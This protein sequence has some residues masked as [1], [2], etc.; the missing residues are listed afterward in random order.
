MWH[1]LPFMLSHHTIIRIKNGEN[2][3]TVPYRQEYSNI[4]SILS[5]SSKHKQH[6][7]QCICLHC[8]A[9]NGTPCPSYWGSYH[10][11]LLTKL[12]FKQLFFWSLDKTCCLGGTLLEKMSTK[13][14]IPKVWPM[15]VNVKF[16]QEEVGTF[17]RGGF[18]PKD[19]I[20]LTQAV[21]Q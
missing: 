10:P 20:P 8:K 15:K 4:S 7:L 2:N 6:A 12:V 14:N 3:S 11:Y 1:L 13:P 16:T 19:K 21:E 5:C 17:T 18:H 9:S